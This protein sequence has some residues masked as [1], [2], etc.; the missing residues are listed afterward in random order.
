MIAKSRVSS[1]IAKY[2]VLRQTTL[3]KVSV[4]K[5]ISILDTAD[6]FESFENFETRTNHRLVRLPI[7]ADDVPKKNSPTSD[8]TLNSLQGVFDSFASRGRCSSHDKIFKIMIVDFENLTFSFRI[9][10]S[11]LPEV[12]IHQAV[13]Q[14]VP[15]SFH[16][17]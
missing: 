13:A 16:R 10:P 15:E 3:V 11:L 7:L 6:N 2:T 14:L 1:L 4:L 5:I 8:Q 12:K 17:F 9:P